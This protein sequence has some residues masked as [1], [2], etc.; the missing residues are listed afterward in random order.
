MLL[1]VAV[2]LAGVLHGLG[3][4]HLAAITAFGAA[5]GR[6]TRLTFFSLRFAAGHAFVILL[7]G[8]AGFFGLHL[9]PPAWEHGFEIGV[10]ALLVAAGVALLGALLTGRLVVHAH[11]HDHQTGR[12]GHYHVHLFGRA[13]H[14]HA[15]GRFAALLGAL[16]ALGGT[17][18]LLAI[19]PI[20]LSA[21]LAES[22]LRIAV[23]AFGIVVAM[24]LYG[25]LAGDAVRRF[26]QPS[27]SLL[28]QRAA[29]ALA[30]AFSVA[31]GLFTIL[32][33]LRS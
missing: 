14:A 33:G 7:A 3:P 9:V 29:C 12:H 32:S 28:P 18:S 11:P 17:R 19:A 2:F 27:G 1:L 6:F 25:W 31:A 4:D 13:G 16:F 5:S 15:H 10:G 30:G 21:T 26:S 22:L 8:L 24:V 23:F 20:A